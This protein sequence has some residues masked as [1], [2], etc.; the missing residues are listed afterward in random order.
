MGI[1]V[2]QLT[3]KLYVVQSFIKFCSWILGLSHLPEIGLDVNIIWVT[4]EF[5]LVCRGLL[6]IN[7]ERSF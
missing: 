1:A 2:V 7:L 4:S 3:G 6:V 5:F